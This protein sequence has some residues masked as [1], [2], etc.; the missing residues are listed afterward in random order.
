MKKF[1]LISLLSSL[2]TTFLST[3]R[4]T[5]FV[6]VAP[7]SPSRDASEA[8]SAPADHARS[9]S[10]SS[11]LFQSSRRASSEDLFAAVHRKEYE[12]NNVKQQH[13]SLSDPVRMAMSYAQETE[14][15]MR[16]AKAL[17][18]VYD[19]V[20]NPANPKYKPKSSEEE[21]RAKKLMDVGMAEMGMRRG[22][23][24]VDI[25]RKSLSRPREIF[26]NYDDAGMVAEAMVRLGADAVFVNVDYQSYGGDMT[27]LKSAVRAV[28]RASDTAAVV[29]KD[30][31]VDEIQLGL[32]KE[33]GADGILLIASVLGPALDNFLNLATAMGLE[34]IV[35]CHT[36]NEVQRAI[37]AL[38]P[39]I[40]VSNYDRVQQRYFPQQAI[41]LAGMFPGSGGPII[42]LAGGGIEDT[43]QMKKHLAVGYD[44]VVVGK[45]VMGS[46]KAPEFIRAVRDRTLL[47]AEFSQWG[48]DD[49]EFDME[50]NVMQG[51]KQGVPEAGDQDVYQ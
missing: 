41:K 20:E 9:T 19:D 34:T 32:A 50:G 29:M 7:S 18:R 4:V 2:F 40:L 43:Q 45:A 51:P 30:I 37:D 26:C 16:L 47:P 3:E 8:T 49:V 12:M 35:E 23:F 5:A 33:A 36:R 31:V 6:A 17:R 39:N 48:L 28:R 27:E 25:K 15:P 44:G 46:P 1:A 10:S 21:K 11:A 22:S 13:R 38:A 42:C 24:I 14:S